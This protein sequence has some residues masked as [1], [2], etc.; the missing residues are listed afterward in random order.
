MAEYRIVDAWY[1]HGYRVDRRRSFG[2]FKF[3]WPVSETRDVAGAI[4]PVYRATVEAA[5][6]EIER[7]EAWRKARLKAKIDGAEYMAE[8][9]KTKGE[10]VCTTTL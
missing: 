8:R 9:D 1:W 6:Y 3:W 7:L 10:I 5:K 2:P 4:G